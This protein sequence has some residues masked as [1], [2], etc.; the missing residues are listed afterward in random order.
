M[1]SLAKKLAVEFIGSFF[2]VFTVGTASGD[3]APFA[4]AGVLAAMIFAGGRVSGAH[5]N[6][7]VTVSVW[8]G[9]GMPA[10]E[11][12][13]YIVSQTAAAFTAGLTAIACAGS[14]DSPA[15]FDTETLLVAEI[16]FTFA[17]CF[18]IL[19]VTTSENSFYGAAIGLVVLAGIISVGSLSGAV[20][21][22]AVAVGLFVKGAADAPGVALYTIANLT[23]GAVAAFVFRLAGENPARES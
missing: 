15:V 18:V 23:G 20:F 22:P 10:R 5:Y 9:G 21:N 2:L 11:V 7:A 8:I 14:A 12:A 1:N 6:P 13:P 4:I 19:N 3:L 16:L 17:L